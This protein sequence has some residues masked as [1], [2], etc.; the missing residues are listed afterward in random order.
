MATEHKTFFGKIFGWV[1]DIFHQSAEKL[2]ND[3]TPEEQASL[4][5]GSGVINVINKHLSDTPETIKEAITQEFPGLDPTAVETSLLDICKHLN[6]T[7][8]T[9]DLNGAIESIKT[10]LSSKSGRVWEWASSALAELLSAI[11]APNTTAFAK[12]STLVEYAY[13]TFIKKD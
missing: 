8:P 13:R 3:L 1:G 2:W 12:I 9:V 5:N 7:P 4:K 11:F 10:Y 6:I